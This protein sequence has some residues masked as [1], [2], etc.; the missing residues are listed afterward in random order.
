[1]RQTESKNQLLAAVQAGDAGVSVYNLLSVPIAPLPSCHRIP[2]VM[3]DETTTDDELSKIADTLVPKHHCTMQ[4]HVRPSLASCLPC[5]VAV[6]D[7][8]AGAMSRVGGATSTS[9][10]PSP[11]GSCKTPGGTVGHARL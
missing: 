11:G 7:A 6:L 9:A 5:A 4:R 3:Q 10:E 8:L 1:M 2:L